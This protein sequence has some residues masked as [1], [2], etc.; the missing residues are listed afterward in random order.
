MIVSG[1]TRPMKNPVDLHIGQRLRHRR[2]L[3]GLTQQQ[4][5][6]AIGT[7]FQQVQKY[8][9]GA[10]RVSAARLWELAK[11]LDVPVW[12]F[13]D[14]LEDPN[15]GSLPHGVGE[16][17]LEQKE[18]LELIRAYYAM[19]EGPRRKLFELA[20]AAGSDKARSGDGSEEQSFAGSQSAA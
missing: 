14:G 6:Q 7:R 16:Q 1:G 9:T 18:T 17:M 5:A 4:V 8:E 3:E 19:A 20:K 2:W 10:N 15:R 11:A 12:F 13:F